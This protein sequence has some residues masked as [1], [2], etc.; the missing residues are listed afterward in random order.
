VKAALHPRQAARLAALHSY[1][2]LD[3]PRE[4]DFDE[5][6][7]LAAT[8]CGAPISVVN[9]I[10][11]D[12]QWFKAE[13]G[14]GVRETPLDTSLCAHAIL[15][16]D[17]MEIED[18][19]ADRRMADNSLCTGEPGLRF[20]A[21]A[22]LKTEDGLPLGTLCVLDYR[23]RRLDDFQRRS[24]K[25]IARQVMKQL[26]L[27]RALK[28]QNTLVKEIDHRV[29]NSL[30]SVSSL[31]AL[32][33]M[34]SKDEHVRAALDEVAARLQTISLV[35]DELSLA[36][37]SE[38]VDLGRYLDRLGGLLARNASG[39][40]KVLVTGE[41]LMANSRLASSVG[42]IVSE[43]VANSLKHA[44]PDGRAGTIR[45]KLR[46]IGEGMAELSCADDGV[47]AP[48]AGDTGKAGLGMK[49]IAASVSQIGGRLERPEAVPGVQLR[50]VF[51][52]THVV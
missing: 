20:Y 30:Q 5:L 28:A 50:V 9:L 52:P 11:A 3:T 47:G 42:M 6:V 19:L 27:R 10:D 14:L 45:I 1:E 36:G 48:A 33:R 31:V 4:S 46:D 22:L 2:I 43:F 8:I 35:H 37:A 17:F 24:L 39:D 16:Q 26:D 41:A 38:T 23:S 32:Q 18:T 34:R 40:V 12:R 21:G 29:K 25:V 51:R 44:F 49:I 7:E 15:E 13:T